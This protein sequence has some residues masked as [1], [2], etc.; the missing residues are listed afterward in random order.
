MLALLRGTTSNHNEDFSCLNCFHSY[1]TNNKL[2][3]H[4]RLCNNH[5]SCYVEKPNEDNKILKYNQGE[6]QL[7]SP[8]IIYAGLGCLLEKMHLCQN[9]YEKSYT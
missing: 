8:A 1:S 9:N 3:K 2:K 5:D 7:K 4:E 6:K